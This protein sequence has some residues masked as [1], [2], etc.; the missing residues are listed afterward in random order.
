MQHGPGGCVYKEWLWLFVVWLLSMSQKYAF[1]SGLVVFSYSGCQCCF[2]KMLQHNT[3][4]QIQYFIVKSQVIFLFF[5]PHRWTI[6]KVI[7]SILVSSGNIIFRPG[8]GCFAQSANTIREMKCHCKPQ[9]APLFF[10]LY[11]KE[12][13]KP[14]SNPAFGTN[15]T[16]LAPCAKAACPLKSV[17]LAQT[18]MHTF[19][20]F[21][22]IAQTSAHRHTLPCPLVFLSWVR[23]LICPSPPP[24]WLDCEWVMLPEG[25]LNGRTNENTNQR[26]H[27][28]FQ[29][30][31]KIQSETLKEGLRRWMFWVHCD[32]QRR[33]TNTVHKRIY[34]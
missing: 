25:V 14:Q 12:G 7:L 24:S 21:S 32:K 28:R 31:G 16:R 3:C 34:D 6:C 18:E 2:I 19:T 5:P 29:E 4:S 13:K 17:T 11:A 27:Q 8:C 20:D 9:I 26:K 1:F 30:M 15:E 33:L 23:Y 22:G 10:P